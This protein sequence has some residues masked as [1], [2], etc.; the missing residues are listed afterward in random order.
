MLLIIE[1]REHAQTYSKLS[2]TQN[3]PDKRSM[4]KP[5]ESTSRDLEHQPYYD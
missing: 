2:S 1:K 5:N 3:D 4:V